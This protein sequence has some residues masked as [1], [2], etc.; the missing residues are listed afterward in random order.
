MS[1]SSS[2]FSHYAP[3]ASR[4]AAGARIAVAPALGGAAVGAGWFGY[5]AV[6]HAGVAA[7]AVT[8]ALA[9]IRAGQATR[10]RAALAAIETTC[11]RISKGDFEAR[12]VG[13]DAKSGTAGAENAVNDAIDRCDAFVRESTAALDAV[14][15]GVYYRFIL[16]EG[17]NGSFRVA[18][19]SIN[20][21]VRN[22]EKAVN[23]ARRDAE[24]EK[25][26]VVATI[27]AGL[28]RLAG[29]DLTARLGDELPAAYG[30][31]RN[32]FNSAL[33]AMETAMQSVKDSAESIASGADEITAASNDLAQRTERQAANL[34]ES[35]AAMRELSQVIDNA[36]SASLHT[37]DNIATANSDAVASLAVVEKTIAAVNSITE[38]SQQI[39]ATIGV[40]D[41][42]AFQTNLLALNAGVEAARAGDAGR[43]FAVVATEVRALAQRSATA[44][45]EIKAIIAQSSSAI[46]QGVQS[47]GATS[48]AF[49]RIKDQIEMIDGGISDI[50]GQALHQT[51]TLR[52]VNIALSEI[53]TMTQQ[54][55]AMA[56]QANSACHSLAAESGKLAGMVA[57]FV[58][59]GAAP[60]REEKR[61]A[62]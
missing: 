30:Q 17:L 8:A 57:E 14:V 62:A 56:E 37:Q 43:G 13:V 2:R 32:D 53:D 25:N 50:A 52:E 15:R 27:A 21:S 40:I 58:V 55:A 12:I 16:L 35:T 59:S 61:R 46:S 23:E 10:F 39:G 3:V 26:H 18:A 47:M 41:E 1:S 5:P 11:R 33:E 9:W 22:H 44:A 28:A 19:E 48:Q 29:K 38:L 31:L 36:A 20:A 34:E 24:A 54:N 45:K 4:L 6:E 7:L 60:A 49:H 51:S 42:I